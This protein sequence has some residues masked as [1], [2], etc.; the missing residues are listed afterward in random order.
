MTTPHSL[1]PVGSNL[2]DVCRCVISDF[3]REVAESCTIHSYYAAR[4]KWEFFLRNYHYSLRNNPE[5]RSSQC[6]SLFAF[7]FI[8]VSILQ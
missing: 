7:H 6:F 4:E 5:E 2:S 8:L 3:R 1:I